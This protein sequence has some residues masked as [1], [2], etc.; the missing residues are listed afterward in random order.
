MA[1]LRPQ[2]YGLLL[3][4]ESAVQQRLPLTPEGLKDST[5]ISVSDEPDWDRADIDPQTLIPPSASD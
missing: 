3:R 1:D 5:T 2:I 4:V